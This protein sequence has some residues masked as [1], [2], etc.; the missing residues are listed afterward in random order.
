MGSLSPAP[1]GP[2]GWDPRVPVSGLGFPTPMTQGPGC[3]WRRFD[4]N[5][6]VMGLFSARQISSYLNWVVRTLSDTEMQMNSVER[7]YH[8]AQVPRERNVGKEGA[9]VCGY[10]CLCGVRSGVSHNAK[11]LCVRVCV[12][13]SVCVR[14]C[15]W[16]YVYVC[17]CAGVQVSLHPGAEGEERGQGKCVCVWGG[18]C[19]RVWV[20]LQVSPERM[21][22]WVCVRGC[23]CV[24][25]L[26]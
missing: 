21:R 9:C 8:Y 7:M 23:V 13:T 10:A 17:A 1:L 12:R 16:V 24:V 2:L 18:M 22:A 11:V 25:R 3:S 15:V 26:Y 19:M 4:R 5:Y 14:V 6:F 20:C